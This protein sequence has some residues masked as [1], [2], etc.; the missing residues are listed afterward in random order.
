M[1]E[2]YKSSMLNWLV[3]KLSNYLEDKEGISVENV[4]SSPSVVHMVVQDSFGFL[5][6]IEIR[7][8]GRIYGTPATIVSEYDSAM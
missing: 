2:K 7:Q 1:T 8:R 6:D 3:G 5:Y 4:S